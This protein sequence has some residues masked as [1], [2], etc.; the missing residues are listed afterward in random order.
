MYDYPTFKI[1]L[2]KKSFLTEIT[3]KERI[4]KDNLSTFKNRNYE[5]VK[6]LIK[7]KMMMKIKIKVLEVKYKL[8]L[9]GRLIPINLQV[10]QFVKII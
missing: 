10:Y 6:I 9:H 1:N 2:N 8:T 4:K 3:F 7:Y 5:L